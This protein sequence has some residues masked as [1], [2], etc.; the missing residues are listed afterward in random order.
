MKKKIFDILTR[1]TELRDKIGIDNSH[2]NAGLAAPSL[3]N[4][5][6]D[7]NSYLV[8]P[9]VDFLALGGASLLFFGGA[10][11]LGEKYH[12][13]R[14]FGRIVSVCGESSTFCAFLS[15]VLSQLF[16]QAPR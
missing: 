4:K 16:E 13:R 5:V 3:A 6:S 7:S 11:V 14:G 2:K 9:V 15:G 12:G 8:S 10:K 1:Y